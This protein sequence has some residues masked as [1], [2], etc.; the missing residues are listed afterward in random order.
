MKKNIYLLM[1]V[2][3]FGLG[4]YLYYNFMYVEQPRKINRLRVEIRRLN[5]KLISAQILAQE[6]DQVAKLIEHNLALSAKDSLA[7][8]ASM[9]FMNFITEE[10][11][12]LE[13]K[14]IKLDPGR[15]QNM[16]DYIKS[17]YRMT[18]EC[19]YEELGRFINQLEKSDRLV[20]VDGFEIDNAIRKIRD[21]AVKRTKANSHRI[22]L[23]ISTLTLIKR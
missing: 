21:T 19:T 6:L 20:T 13:I 17:P 2:F 10:M 15:K 18:I 8:D 11:E 4:S 1:I 22:E 14:L 3:L 7:E 23:A 12:S 5:E 16:R 9:P